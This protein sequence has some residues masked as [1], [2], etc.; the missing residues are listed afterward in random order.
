MTIFMMAASTASQ[1]VNKYRQFILLAMMSLF[2]LVLSGCGGGGGGSS[3]SAASGGGGDSGQLVL[4]L[5]DA[6]GDFLSYIVDVT[7]ITLVH[8]NGSVVEALPL[9]TA[10]DFA[11]YVEL[12]E[13]LTIATVPVGSYK[14][15][16]LNLDYSNAMV[17]VQADDGTP[18]TASL[19]DSEGN[20]LSQLAVSIE[21][22]DASRF[23]IA[24]GVPAQVTLD[25]DLDASNDVVIDNGQAV[26]TVEPILLA[27]TILETPKPFRL[28]GLLNTVALAEEVFSIDLL[29]F[30]HHQRSFGSVRVHV[31]SETRYQIDGVAYEAEQGLQQLASKAE[32]TPVVSAGQ[33]SREL[34]LFTATTVYAGSS[35][36]WSDTTLLRG[37]VVARD[38]NAL[39]VRG[40]LFEMTDGSHVVRDTVTVLLGV[41]TRVSKPFVGT[42]QTSIADISIGSAI[43]ASGERADDNTL[44][45]SAGKVRIQLSN[46]TGSVVSASPLSVDL[47]RLSGRSAASYDFSGTGTDTDSDANPDSYEID[48]SGLQLASLAIGD[49][50]RVRGLVSMFGTAPEDFV[51]NT[52]IDVSEVKGHMLINFSRAGVTT[53]LAQLG[54]DGL[55]F[56]ISDAEGRSLIV[57]AGIVTQLAELDAVPLVVPAA[58]AGIY[59]ISRRGR[60][61]IFRHFAEFVTALD[62]ALAAGD[63]VTRFDA[64]GHYDALQSSF[65]SSRLRIGLSQ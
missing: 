9:T 7:S 54:E 40:G 43:I 30:R 63:R 3:D 61:E 39:T 10:I 55:L 38:N 8:Q 24:P 60:I 28:R 5:T 27:D 17:T 51:A 41:D 42:D 4:A 35:V 45:A 21:L 52:V 22:S 1:K 6:E 44:D 15:V 31:N 33:W 58:D 25:L 29:P 14:S 65:S 57:R 2:L 18:L 26:V 19:V 20:S 37:V 59:A 50:L 23:V 49:P 56:D 62:Q 13:L 36:M 53:A 12:S 34:K 64:H 11:Q 32:D 16:Q 48:S 47:Q 46:V